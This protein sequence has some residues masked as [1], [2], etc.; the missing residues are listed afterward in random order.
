M[1]IVEGVK[2]FP[3]VLTD[4]SVSQVRQGSGQL[5]MKA[6][7]HGQG[8]PCFGDTPTKWLVDWLTGKWAS[9]HFNSASGVRAI[10]KHTGRGRG[11]KQ[12]DNCSV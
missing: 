4:A 1:Y 11:Q 5:N 3:R 7:T 9:P 6:T 2:S 8:L 12:G 10:D